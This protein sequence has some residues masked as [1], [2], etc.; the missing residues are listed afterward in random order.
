[1]ASY[2]LEITLITVPNVKEP[3]HH[4]SM[5]IHYVCVQEVRRW[6]LLT[7]F[8]SWPDGSSQG[9][10]THQVTQVES[11][12]PQLEPKSGSLTPVPCSPPFPMV[13]H[14]CT[15][16][17]HGG[18]CPALPMRIKGL[19]WSKGNSVFLCSQKEVWPVTEREPRTILSQR[20]GQFVHKSSSGCCSWFP[21][22]VGGMMIP[23]IEIQAHGGL[24]IEISFALSVGYF[25]FFS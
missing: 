12:A 6:I 1:M 5:W 10:V 9:Q 7:T 17:C 3:A 20:R 15:V 14:P 24:R 4:Y 2:I 18:E 8:Y 11:T 19:I 25:L 23:S 16:S 22:S 21:G 13:P